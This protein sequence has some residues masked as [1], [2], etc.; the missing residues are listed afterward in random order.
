MVVLPKFTI[1]D[2]KNLTVQ[3]I[4]ITVAGISIIDQAPAPGQTHPLIIEHSMRIITSDFYKIMQELAN[5]QKG[6]ANHITYWNDGLPVRSCSD[7]STF[8]RTYDAAEYCFEMST[9][10]D[11]MHY[12]AIAPLYKSMELHCSILFYKK[13]R[14]I[15]DLSELL[16][17]Y[18]RM[19]YTIL[20]ILKIIYHEREKFDY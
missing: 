19:N 5:L 1:P 13:Q 12:T 20:L 8:S 3:L 2:K 11:Q 7:Q 14:A 4:E 10:R 18:Y 16:R 9:D 6:G 17:S 15:I